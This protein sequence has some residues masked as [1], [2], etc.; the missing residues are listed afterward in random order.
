VGVLSEVPKVT[1]PQ[2]PATD[3]SGPALQ[4]GVEW[5]REE[6]VRLL[7]DQTNPDGRGAE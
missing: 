6:A 7:G 5:K 4:M 2:A 3:G 1:W